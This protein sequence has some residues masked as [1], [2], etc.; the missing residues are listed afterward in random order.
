MWGLLAL[1]V[2]ELDSLTRNLKKAV[3]DCRVSSIKPTISRRFRNTSD[4]FRRLNLKHKNGRAVGVTRSSTTYSHLQVYSFRR[5][6]PEVTV[7]ANRIPALNHGLKQAEGGENLVRVLWPGPE[8]TLLDCVHVC[9]FAH[10]DRLLRRR[11]FSTNELRKKGVVSVETWFDL[12][13][14]R[15][16]ILLASPIEHECVLLNL[17]ETNAIDCSKP[18]AGHWENVTADRDFCAYWWLLTH[19]RKLALDL[20]PEQTNVFT[21]QIEGRLEVRGDHDFVYGWVF[22]VD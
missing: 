22:E 19:G 20:L 14:S 11:D 10:I 8:V 13:I 12:V 2:F 9:E 7:E 1:P 21:A 16:R 15:V 4:L 6:K 18:I 17:Y 3:H 5:V